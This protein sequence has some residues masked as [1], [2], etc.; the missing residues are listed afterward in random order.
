MPESIPA[1]LPANTID[2]V[3][4]N[5]ISP[6]TRTA[7]TLHDIALNNVRVNFIEPTF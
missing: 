1:I 4:E 5:A 3:T 2:P 6:V 7:I